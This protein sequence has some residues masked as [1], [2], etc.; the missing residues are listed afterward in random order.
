MTPVSIV[1]IVLS[2]AS[3]G[4]AWRRL[5][6]SRLFLSV[7]LVIIHLL[8]SVYYYHYSQ[9]AIADA[10]AYYYDPYNWGNAPWGLSTKFVVQL[11]YVLKIYVGASYLDCF[12]I[13]Q[14]FGIAGLMILARTFDEIEANVGLADRPG[15][16]ALLYLPSAS[17]WTAAIGKD[18]PLFFAVAL[19]V[20][21]ILKFRARFLSFCFAIV[22][23][24]L[25]R[26]HIALLAVSALAGAALFGS[27]VGMAQKL[28]L[29]SVALLGIVLTSG[30]VE[31]SFGVD[32]TSVSSVSEFLDEQNSVYA[33]M[34]GTTSLGDAPFALRVVSLLFRPLFFDAHGVLGIIASIEN[35]GVIIAVIYVIRNWRDLAYLARRVVFVRFVMIFA[36][37]TLL[38]LSIV[39]YNVGLGLR[40]R[41]MAYPTLFATLVSLWSMRQKRSLLTAAQ[42]QVPLM[43]QPKAN[44]PAPEL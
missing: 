34:Q 27:S 6:V 7:A 37:L 9:V 40:Q 8:A 15:F 11:C 17:F 4:L 38:A 28:G 44:R 39:Y 2:F 18:A 5:T 16:W 12:L 25:F 24:V 13:F 20:W 1:A 10:S 33:G 32:P 21:A 23:M 30:A 26:A 3:I 19:C 42:A 41:V 31:S 14:T 22:L 36:F 35:V 43:V 29:M